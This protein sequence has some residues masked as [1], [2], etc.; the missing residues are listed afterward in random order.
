MAATDVIKTG[1][2]VSGKLTGLAGIYQ[3]LSA[4]V[5]ASFWFTVCNILQQ[6]ISMLTVPV[7]TRLLTPEQY[8]VYTDYQ[9]WYAIISIFATLNLSAGVFNNGM[10]KYEGDKSGYMASLQGLSTTVTVLLFLVYLIGM[11]F[12]N[13]CLGLSTLFIASMFLQ[14]LFIPAYQFWSAR[15]R[16]E[17]KYRAL[18]GVTLIIAAGSPIIGIIAV[19][20]TSYKAEARI[21][22]FVLVQSAVGLVFYIFNFL[23][24]RLF[25]FRFY[26]KY[27]LTFNIPL[28][29]HYLALTLLGQVG[30]IMINDMAGKEKAAIYSVAYN[31]SL[32]IS[33]V[34]QAINNS[35]IPYTYKALKDK[36]YRDIGD[37]ADRLLCLVG[38]AS[39]LAMLLGPE[40]I[41]IF[42]PAE[43]YEAVWIIPPAVAGA[44]FAYLYPLFGNIEFYFEENTYIM[45]ASIFGAVINVLLNLVLIPR[46][47]YMAAGYSTLICYILFGISHS[48]FYRKVCRKHIPGIRIYRW[49]N[50]V[51][52]SCIVLISM[53]LMLVVYRYS[54]IR[55]GI[56]AGLA[57][58]AAARRQ[59]VAELLKKIRKQ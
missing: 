36:R 58:I 59:N 18:I 8:G 37:N 10:I 7:F 27:A 22:S 24:G 12:W 32:L 20:A 33:L 28:L 21:L 45:L 26:W 4:P 35:F 38:V 48:F 30:R 29:P 39:A 5:K 17:Y 42:A 19:L 9:S 57:V 13:R 55:Y 25:F 50:I 40:V 31:I 46:Y 16:F 34:T 53:V 2:R 44:F 15:Q 11:D 49:K 54:L 52:V 23:K 41:K 43:Y 6:G 56:L 3:S 47:G 14:A 51:V 1:S